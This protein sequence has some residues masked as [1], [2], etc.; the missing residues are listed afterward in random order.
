MLFQRFII[1]PYKNN[2]MIYY[3]EGIPINYIDALKYY[4]KE[5]EL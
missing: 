4:N 2:P 3:L 5:I 1:Q